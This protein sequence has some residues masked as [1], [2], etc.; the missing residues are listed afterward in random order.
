[1]AVSEIQKQLNPVLTMGAIQ[2]VTLPYTATENG[3]LV[4]SIKGG[5]GD[6]YQQIGTT[7]GSFICITVS[8][9]TVDTTIPLKKGATASQGSSN[10]VTTRSYRFIPLTVSME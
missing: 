2:T 9:W 7:N 1:M 10:N 6:G 8:G 3:F 5:A 4:C